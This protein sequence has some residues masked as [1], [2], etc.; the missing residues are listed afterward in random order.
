[1]ENLKFTERAI[2]AN[3]FRILS[4]LDKDNKE[5]HLV[6]AE[7]FECGYTGLYAETLQH[8]YS[9]GTS[10]EVCTETHE[11]LTMYRVI[12]SAIEA[13]TPQEKE[14]LDLQRIKFDGFDSHDK[15]YHFAMFMIEKQQKYREHSEHDIDSHSGVSIIRYRSMLPVYK[16]LI[17]DHNYNLS[18]KGLQELIDAV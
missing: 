1:M 4:F 7:V 6:S 16:K 11:I 13:L 12:S 17:K 8:I 15:H 10:R 3:Q 5:S 9:E 2:L 18:V 14:S